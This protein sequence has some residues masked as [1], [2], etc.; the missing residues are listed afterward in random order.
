VEMSSVQEAQRAYEQLHNTSLRKHVMIIRFMASSPQRVKPKKGSGLQSQATS[1]KSDANGLSSDGSQDD[2]KVHDPKKKPDS[3]SEYEPSDYEPSEYEPSDT[4]P[5][6]M[7]TRQTAEHAPNDVEDSVP[8]V[9][10]IA[11][12]HSR[13]DSPLVILD[14]TDDA[15]VCLPLARLNDLTVL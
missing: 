1:S 7:T 3:E 12:D 9:N 13:A 10:D 14:T 5:S 6:S 8:I 4:M 2:V 11:T 15:Q